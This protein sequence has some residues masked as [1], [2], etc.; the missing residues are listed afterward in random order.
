MLEQIWQNIYLPTENLNNNFQISIYNNPLETE[1]Y[2][3][4]L[5]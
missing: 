5:V 1:L 3:W 2:T 4:A